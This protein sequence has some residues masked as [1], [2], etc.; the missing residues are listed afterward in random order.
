MRL[1]TVALLAAIA[2]PSFGADAKSADTGEL[3]YR[4]YR[5]WKINLPAEKWF[6]VN[7]GI[8]IKH[9]GGDRFAAKLDGERLQFDTDGDGKIDRTIKALVDRDTN[10]ST[11]RVILTGQ[12]KNGQALKYAVRLRK[13]ARGWEWAPGGAMVGSL[14][15]ENGPIPVR[16]VDQNGNG[17]FDDIGQ[18]AMTIGKSDDATFLS[19]TVLLGKELREFAVADAGF[20]TK[21]F[22][23]ETAK[24]DVTTSFDSKAVLL[25]T[26]VQSKDGKNSFNLASAKGAATVPAGTY[27]VVSGL[28]GLGKQRVIIANGRMKPITVAKG[29][30]EAINWGGPVKSEF[31]YVRAGGQVQF[32]P[33]TVWFYGNAG[34]EYKGWVPC[35]KSPEFTVKDKETGNVIE[36]AILPG[37]C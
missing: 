37:S 4:S 23:G 36:V 28:V 10:V 18:D 32:S 22:K 19:Q 11:S 9:A 13:D 8:R 5:T 21:P 12:D 26:I 2:A 15:T 6:Q 17:R 20:T 3:R 31:R 35:G 33:D 29:E 24:L 1:L 7:D 30:A 34:E 14:Q 27:N 25:T 16:I